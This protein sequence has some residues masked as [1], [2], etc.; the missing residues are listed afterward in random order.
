M[1]VEFKKRPLF[2]D[3]VSEVRTRVFT[4]FIWTH[5]RNHFRKAIKHLIEWEN[6][7]LLYSK[8]KIKVDLADFLDKQVV[9]ALEKR[10]RFFKVEIGGK[11]PR[12]RQLPPYEKFASSLNDFR[13]W[14]NHASQL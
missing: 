1:F 14:F 9:E 12:K 5:L 2:R 7:E 6:P 4:K 8:L 3:I 13:N 11:A 10:Q